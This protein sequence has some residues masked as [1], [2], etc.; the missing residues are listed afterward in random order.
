MSLKG[1][2]NFNHDFF[3]PSSALKEES[4]MALVYP[5]NLPG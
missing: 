1:I 5:M 4:E 3:H 2:S